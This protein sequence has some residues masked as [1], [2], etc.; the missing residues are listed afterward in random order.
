MLT[1]F[2]FVFFSVFFISSEFCSEE[3]I[4]QH[5]VASHQNLTEGRWWS[6]LLSNFMHADIIHLLLNSYALYELYSLTVEEYGL[7]IFLSAYFFSAMVSSYVQIYIEPEKGSVGASGS[8]YCLDAMLIIALIMTYEVDIAEV[9]IPIISNEVYNVCS[10]TPISHWAHW[11]GF[12][13]GII[14]GLMYHL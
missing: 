6:L 11:S 3:E 9:V 7:V 8:I 14:L 4:Q 12:S 1:V 10:D 2:L 5:F 13:V